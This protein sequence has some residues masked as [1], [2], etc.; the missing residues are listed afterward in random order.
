MMSP[1]TDASTGANRKVKAFGPDGKP[2]PL[3]SPFIEYESISAIN[4]RIIKFSLTP[5]PFGARLTNGKFFPG[6]S[7]ACYGRSYTA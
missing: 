2:L 1:T 6:N 4:D 7:S 3:P 5:T